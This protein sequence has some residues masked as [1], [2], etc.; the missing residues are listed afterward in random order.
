MTDSQARE[1]ARE[2]YRRFTGSTGDFT[3]AEKEEVNA[4][5]QALISAR[6][7]ALEEAMKAAQSPDEGYLHGCPCRS[8]IRALKEKV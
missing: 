7:E 4:L 8:R 3:L 1:K 5:A 2:L 6:Q